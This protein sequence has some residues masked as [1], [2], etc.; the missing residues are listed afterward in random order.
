MAFYCPVCSGESLN[1]S[2]SLELP[3]SDYDDEI[4]VQM[5]ECIA[6]SFTGLAVYCESRRGSMERPSWRHRGYQIEREA[7]ASLSHRFSQCPSP[8]NPRC[9]C[10]THAYLSQYDWAALA[11]NFA[12]KKEFEMRLVPNA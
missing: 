2:F 11:S 7:L 1:I 9:G 6:C 5:V 3:P 12:V 10:P 8:G 4:T